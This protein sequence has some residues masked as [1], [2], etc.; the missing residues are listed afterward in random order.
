MCYDLGIE[1]CQKDIIKLFKNF[2]TVGHHAKATKTQTVDFD[3]FTRILRNGLIQLV[4]IALPVQLHIAV[5]P[6]ARAPTLTRALATVYGVDR[7][8]GSRP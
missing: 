7:T 2:R 1:L 3:T 6:V 5:G 4:R 8:R